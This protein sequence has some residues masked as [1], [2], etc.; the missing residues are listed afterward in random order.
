MHRGYR[1]PNALDLVGQRFGR[2]TV[3]EE[4]PKRTYGSQAVRFWRC[5]CDCDGSIDVSTGNL[6]STNTNSCGCGKTGTKYIKVRCH[7]PLFQIWS[8]MLKRC[9]NAK[10]ASFPQ[11]GGRGIR[12]CDRWRGEDGFWNFVTDIG[13]RPGLG[14]SV[15]RKDNDG[16]YSPENCRWATP[17]QQGNNNRRTRWITAFGQTKTMQQWAEECGVRGS[18]LKQRMDRDG[19]T[20]EDA[21]RKSQN[22]ALHY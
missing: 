5:K 8:T 16:P 20:P 1:A 15:D 21:I 9:Y 12:V 3:T 7:H 4:L 10:S 17:S 14:Y 13:P 22:G 18:L 11:Y 6:R 2:L 19:L